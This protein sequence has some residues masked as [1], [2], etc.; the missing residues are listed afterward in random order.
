MDFEDDCDMM[1]YLMPH[2]GGMVEQHGKQ[3]S[4]ITKPNK[5]IKKTIIINNAIYT[6]E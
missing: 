1:M 6:D 2:K 4:T 3:S 5:R